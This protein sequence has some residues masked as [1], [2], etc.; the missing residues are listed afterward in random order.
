MNFTRY[1]KIGTVF[2]LIVLLVGGGYFYFKR[3]TKKNKKSKD[4]DSG[5]EKSQM[6]IAMDIIMNDPQIALAMLDPKVRAAFQEIQSDLKNAEKYKDDPKIGP[7]IDKVMSQLDLPNMKKEKSKKS[8]PK[9]LP[10]KQPSTNVSKPVT[11]PKVVAK[12]ITQDIS[13]QATQV[14]QPQGFNETPNTVTLVSDNS[15]ISGDIY[16]GTLTLADSVKGDNSGTGVVAG[17][18]ISSRTGGGSGGSSS[19]SNRNRNSRS[20]RRSNN[21]NANDNNSPANYDGGYGGENSWSW[22]SGT[23][24]SGAQEDTSSIEPFDIYEKTY[25]FL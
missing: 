14:Q 13:N 1:L 19:S 4:G 8:T 3:K 7:L 2:L 23:P 17:R 20:S 18:R 25:D 11:R 22:D 24:G 15:A 12:E 5:E 9:K 21:N 16:G 10:R 6:D